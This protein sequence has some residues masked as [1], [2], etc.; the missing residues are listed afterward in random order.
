MAFTD[1]STSVLNSIV[2]WDWD[3]AGLGTSTL[4]NPGYTFL[5]DGRYAVTK[6]D[7][8][9]GAFK[10][11]TLRQV[12]DTAPYMHDGSLA[13]LAKVVNPRTK[14]I[15]INS[16]NNPTGKLYP[17]ETLEAL[18]WWEPLA[19]RLAPAADVRAALRLVELG[20]A[21]GQGLIRVGAREARVDEGD[22][23]FVL[24]GVAV[25][26]TQAGDGHGQL[27][28]QHVRRDLGHL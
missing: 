24:E 13:T 2:T 12:S 18:G 3:F 26:V 23:V 17:R 10:T 11:P 14:G 4:Q 1:G 7:A 8:D 15:I 5:D 28:P 19:D 9:R 6:K 25:D 27:H 22:A 21:G 16:P 20:E